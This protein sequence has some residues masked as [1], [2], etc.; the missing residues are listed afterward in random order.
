MR[1]ASNLNPDAVDQ[2]A[3][4]GERL[5]ADH[6][7]V[8][9]ARM[10]RGE[11]LLGRDVRIAGDPVLGRRR[12]ALPVVAVGEPD[13]QIR[14]RPGIMQRVKLLAVQPFR[15]AAESRIMRG[16]GRDRIVA[17]DARGG[18]DRLRKL[19]DGDVILVSGKDPLRP[20]RGRIG[21][22][23]PIDVEAGD[24]FQSRLIGDRVRLVGARDLG[25]VRLGQQHG[26]FADNGEPRRIGGE[27]PGDALVEPPGRAV[28]ARLGG[29]AE[30]RERDLLVGENRRHQPRAGLIGLL[31]RS[32]SPKAAPRPAR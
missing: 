7:A 9:P 32:A 3:L 31:R 4:I 18:E 24:L 30:A 13:G 10:R 28:E 20:R 19:A 22:D 27:S 26:I 29:E 23:V 25:R 17:I 11:D 16:P 6:M 2:R 8:D 15:P 1:P 5:G 14:A 12:A 21:H